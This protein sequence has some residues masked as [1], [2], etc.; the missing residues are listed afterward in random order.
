MSYVNMDHADWVERNNAAGRRNHGKPRRDRNCG[1]AIGYHAAPEKLTEFQAKVMNILGIVGGGIYNAPI[2]WATV[3]WAGDGGVSLIWR[4]GFSTF[5]PNRLTT[6]VFL[7]H[8]ARIRVSVGPGGPRIMRLS[9]FQRSN[10][11]STYLR[12]P[13]L[14]EAVAAHREIM[15]LD[16]SIVYPTPVEVDPV[17]Q[18]RAA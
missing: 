17:E 1:Y 10:E 6:L 14:E 8:D 16:H 9:F 7:C 3:D 15:Q 2:T 12:H 11:G 18:E 4:G 5:D 13:N